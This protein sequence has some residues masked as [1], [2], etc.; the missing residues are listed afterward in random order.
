[1]RT[2]EKKSLKAGKFVNAAHVSNLIRNY[3]KERWIQNSERLGKKDSLGVWLSAEELEEFV[4]VAK[5]HGADGVRIYFGVYGDK[6]PKAGM[7]GNQTVALVATQESETEG[8]EIVHRD[9]VIEKDGA[10]D[11]VAYNFYPPFGCTPPP[12]HD[13]RFPFLGC[14]DHYRQAGEN[15]GYLR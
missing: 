4:Q 10:R 2:I 8:A 9:L 1:M 6:A 12:D 5:M 11:I 14:H 15:A 3:K 13:G 7:E